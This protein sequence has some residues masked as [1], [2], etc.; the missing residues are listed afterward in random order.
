ML[1]YEIGLGK[2]HKKQALKIK[3]IGKDKIHANRSPKEA[4][5]DQTTV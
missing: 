5:L 2:N 1:E 3:V 4:T